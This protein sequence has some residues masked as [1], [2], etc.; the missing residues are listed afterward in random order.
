MNKWEYACVPHE[1]HVDRRIVRG[2]LFAVLVD[3]CDVLCE[4]QVFLGVWFVLDEPEQV[5]TWKQCCRKLDVL[6]NA[7]PWVV[8]TKCRVCRRQDRTTCIQRR[9][10]ACL[11]HR[12]TNTAILK[13]NFIPFTTLR[14]FFKFW[15]ATFLLF[16]NFD[17]YN[18]IPEQIYR[19]T[20]VDHIFHFVLKNKT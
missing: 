12:H 15:S 20:D 7:F 17:I 18:T 4:L 8:A 1:L 3:M 11:R 13:I 16:I 5:K 19:L 10:Y 6:L 9:H 14:I 2:R